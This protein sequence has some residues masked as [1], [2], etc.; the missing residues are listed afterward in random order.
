MSLRSDYKTGWTTAV[1]Q[2]SNKDY[3]HTVLP[4]TKSA[5]NFY[6]GLKRQE[7]GLNSP[8]QLAGAMG[9]RVLTDLG[10]DSTRQMYWRYNHPMAISEKIGEKIIGEGIKS[11]SPTQRAAIGLAAIGIPVGASVGTFDLT[12]LSEYGRPKGFAQSYAE[13]GSEDRRE[14]GQLAP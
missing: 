3:G 6:K 2:M 10:T 14:T 11:Y 4:I 1:Q 9:A 13:Q 7:I 5:R 12:N 8:K